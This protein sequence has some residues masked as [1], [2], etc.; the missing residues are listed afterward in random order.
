MRSYRDEFGKRVTRA[1]GGFGGRVK[2]AAGN[3]LDAATIGWVIWL[4]LWLILS[5]VLMRL[6]TAA[7]AQHLLAAIWGFFIGITMLIYFHS[8][9]L[10]TIVGGVVGVAITDLSGLADVITKAGAAIKKITDALNSALAADGAIQPLSGWIFFTIIL[11]CCLPA[12]KTP[13]PE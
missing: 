7:V 2:S 13:T 8:K 10:I 11:L 6:L 4:V 9:I 1:L 3:G 5:F 12:Y